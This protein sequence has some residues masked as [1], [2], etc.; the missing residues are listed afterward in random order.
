[1][2]ALA[3]EAKKRGFQVILRYNGNILNGIVSIP[4]IMEG[5]EGKY[6]LFLSKSGNEKSQTFS[7]STSA[8]AIA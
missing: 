1:M 7:A 5:F 4:P 2:N 6:E 3:R 8:V